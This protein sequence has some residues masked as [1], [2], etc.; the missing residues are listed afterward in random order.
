MSTM[1]EDFE[2][3]DT[4]L[5]PRV[6]RLRPAVELSDDQLF[7]LCQINPDLRI[8]CNKR[9]DLIMMSPAGSESSHRNIEIARQLADWAERDGTGIAFDS[10]GGFRLRKRAMRS[11]DG[12][13]IRLTRWN[14]LTAEQK[15]KF[16]PICPD[17]VIE[18]RSE[19]D[20]L[21]TLK[22]KMQEYLEHG[23]R[24]GLLIDPFQQKVYVYRQ[25]RD[26]E[27]LGDPKSVSCG[28]VLRGFTLELKRI[29]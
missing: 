28:P 23:A 26:V 27:V 3:V 5:V 2:D 20:R 10:S 6:L 11:P 14:K 13:W 17:F 9:G 1:L 4:V 12:A 29:W 24:M 18:L 25:G 22:K 8:E 16:A 19:T 21:G 15:K 7:E